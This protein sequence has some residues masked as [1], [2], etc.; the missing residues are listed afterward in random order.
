MTNNFG[1]NISDIE[2]G[3]NV[4]TTDSDNGI[5]KDIRK[6]EVLPYFV[7][8]SRHLSHRLQ[9]RVFRRYCV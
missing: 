4:D 9:D 2:I 8:F 6:N 7:E 3:K 5:I 1:V